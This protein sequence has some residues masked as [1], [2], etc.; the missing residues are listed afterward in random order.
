MKQKFKPKVWVLVSLLAFAGTLRAAQT[1]IAGPVASTEFGSTVTVLPNGNFVVTAPK[2]DIPSGPADVGRVYLYSGETLAVIS[3]LTG[4]TANDQIGGSIVVL[5][6]G[7]FLVV[8]SFWDNTS[9]AAVDAGAVTW[10]SGTTGCA[11]TVSSANSLV[12]ASANDRIGVVDDPTNTCSSISGS[13]ITIL[14]NGN[15]VI[16]SSLWDASPTATD[17]GAV[18]WGNG[19]TGTSGVVSS[20]NSLVGTTTN[21]QVGNGSAAYG[22]GVTALKNGNYVVRTFLWDA[23][24]TQTDV[25]AVTWGNGTTGTSGTVSS[26]NSLVG[27]TTGDRLGIINTSVKTTIVCTMRTSGVVALDNGN[28]VV[29]S[30]L[31]DASVSATDVGAITWGNGA[32]GITGVVSASN[33]LVGSTTD[34]E[35]GSGVNTGVINTMSTPSGIIPL[36]NGNYVVRSYS[37]DNPSPLTANVG[38]VTWCNGSTGLTGPVSSSNSLVGSRASDEVG[39]SGIL[40]LTNGNYVVASQYWDLPSPVTSNVGAATWCNGTTGRVGAVS[41]ANSLVGSAASDAIGAGGIRALTSGNYVVLSS[42]WNANRGAVTF[43]DGATGVTGTV[44]SSNSLVGSASNDR[45]G[46][47]LVTPLTN[48]SYVVGSPLWNNGGTTVGAATW[49]SATGRTGT[50][51]TSNSLY[52]GIASDSVGGSVTALTNGNYVVNTSYF[53]NASFAD[54]G[55]VTWGNGTTGTTG[56]VSSTN[57]LVGSRASDNVGVGGIIALPNGN[58]V[59]RSSNW[60]SGSTA[61]AGAVTWGNG[62]G[63][64]VGAVSSS[65]S[66]VGSRTNDIVGSGGV[67]ALSN[68][69]Y[70]VYSSG[71]DSGSSIADARAVT[72]AKGTGGTTGSITSAASGGNSVVGTVTGGISSGAAPFAFDAAQNRLFVGRSASNAVSILFFNTTATADGDIATAGNWSNGLP[73]GLKS[74]IIPSGRSMT[75]SSKVNAGLIQVQCGGDLTGGSTTAY[76]IGSVRR[77]FC[78]AA[79]A[80]FT[81]PIGDANDY[82]PM[83]A[84]S[85]NGTGSLTA[86]VTKGSLTDLPPSTSLSRYW[87]LSGS[88]ITTS[89][90]FNYVDGDVNGTEGNYRL[91]KRSESSNT[92]VSVTPSILNTAANTISTTGVSQFSAWSAGEPGLAPTA[93]GVWVEGRVVTPDGFGLRNAIVTLTMANG[94]SVQARTSAFGYFR[95]EN[96]EA[97]QTVTLTVASK[98]FT[99]TPRLVFV[100]DNVGDIDLAAHW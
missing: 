86:V 97:G 27:S 10:C 41:A 45:I 84:S 25:G 35:L 75:V 61:D 91:F 48:G 73:D 53:D 77:D 54:I 7:N 42:N 79:G 34:D 8:S 43:G 76:I 89:L 59:V 13:G 29:G 93:A 12:G 14:A 56:A 96:I 38:A 19:A 81:Y 50:V 60:D 94:E 83:T 22:A 21:D 44:S 31:W 51:S 15:Y 90:L 11:G 87:S 23:S 5:P 74:G 32:A 98:R 67:T 17:V 65:N 49:C 57:S 24:P 82:S 80:S 28:Y 46:W 39:G 52:G 64:T 3:T 40:G 6:S 16:S 88:G 66:L 58:Y 100:D 62:A 47:G 95:F 63:G 78:S 72:L 18:T 71:W 20:A 9:P 4:S 37:W 30:S 68:G 85:V 92:T 36:T 33:S 99:F 70:L 26:S 55:A 2:Y 1:D 69:N